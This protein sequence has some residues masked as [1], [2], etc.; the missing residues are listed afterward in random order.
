LHGF[1]LL[2]Y[3]KLYP[4][5]KPKLETVAGE[6]KAKFT[7]LGIFSPKLILG[8]EGGE[9]PVD[10]LLKTATEGIEKIKD[11]IQGAVASAG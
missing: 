10:K 2:A 6:M 7:G 3:Q 5:L 11:E 1:G 8:E 9:G 4:K